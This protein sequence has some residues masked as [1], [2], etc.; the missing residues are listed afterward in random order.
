[1]SALETTFQNANLG[2]EN[3]KKTY[4]ELYSILGDEGKASEAATHIAQLVDTE[5]ELATPWN[6]LFASFCCFIICLLPYRSRYWRIFSKNR[7]MPIM[8]PTESWKLTES[9]VNG[10]A[11]SIT[12]TAKASAVGPSYSRSSTMAK[13]ISDCIIQALVMDAVKPVTAANRNSTG[14]PTRQDNTRFFDTS[15]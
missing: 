8:H 7:K 1:M 11:L 10:L 9:M 5:T 15:V 13:S 6:I 14:I 2:A 12:S 3:A 4:G